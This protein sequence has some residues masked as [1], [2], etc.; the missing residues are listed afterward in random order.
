MT[1]GAAHV[2][3]NCK[4]SWIDNLAW[5]YLCWENL[6][7]REEQMQRKVQDGK[8]QWRTAYAVFP[9]N[10]QQETVLSSPHQSK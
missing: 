8:V 4:S 6:K 3:C 10:L 7:R 9:D 1:Y 2:K 5:A